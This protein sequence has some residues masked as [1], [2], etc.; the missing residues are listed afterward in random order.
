MNIRLFCLLGLILGSAITALGQSKRGSL[1]GVWQAVQVTLG[2]PQASTVKP[3]PNLTIF[4]GKHYSRVDV[5]TEKSRPVLA[6][7]ATA[8]AEELR[9]VWGPFVAEGGTF[10]LTA[11]LITLR[12]IVSKNPAAMAPDVAIVYSYKLEGDTLTVT[13]QRDR[14]GPVANPVT[15]KLVRIE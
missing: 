6:N 11:N 1:D 4:F 8:T 7:P 15:V 14:T 9:E 13:A 12:P 3:G 10:E 2:G 5:H